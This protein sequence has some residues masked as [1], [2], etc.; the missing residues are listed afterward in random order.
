MTT[1]ESPSPEEEAR[2]RRLLADARETEPMPPDVVARLEAALGELSPEQAAG[3]GAHVV[4][5]HRR[6]RTVAGILAAAAVVV[7]G[8]VGLSQVFSGNGTDQT[9]SDSAQVDRAPD[10]ALAGDEDGA[11]LQTPSAGDAAPEEA[12][13]E[14]LPGLDPEVR[15]VDDDAPVI[16]RRDLQRDVIA[17]RQDLP[18]DV[19]AFWDRPESVL[20]TPPEFEC[21]SAPWGEGVLVGV[22]YSGQHAVLAFREPTE[23][24]QVAEVLQCGTGDPLRSVTLAAP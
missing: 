11:R 10:S 18:D 14:S 22:R 17:V 23:Q 7:V 15:M 4:R 21:V 9:A 3:G 2:L 8:G 19:T 16:R 5:F 12:G 20:L 1:P 6:R 13:A 24:T